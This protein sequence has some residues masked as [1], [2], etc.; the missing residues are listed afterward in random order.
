MAPGNGGRIDV[1]LEIGAKKVFACAVDWPGWARWGKTETD[2]LDA[3]VAYGKRYARAVASARAGFKPPA[4]VDELRVVE[5][6]KGN[7]TTDFGA[8]GIPRTADKRPLTAAELKR[9]TSLLEATWRTFDKAAAKAVGVKLT[10][11]PRGGGRSL[12][13]MEDHVFEAE[14]GYLHALGSRVPRPPEVASVRKTILAALA[15]RATDKPLPDPNQVDP[16]KRW[17]PR[18]FIRRTAWHAL[19][20]AWELEDRS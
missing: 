8:P 2:A 15:A 7:A 1:Y 11:G 9:Q 20:H 5:R 4:D 16:A 12:P 10:V 18:F 3:L 19:D 6:L 14:G 13:K 17:S